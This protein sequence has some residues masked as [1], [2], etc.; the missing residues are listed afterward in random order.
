[1][2]FAMAVPAWML[3]VVSST[4]SAQ[5]YDVKVERNVDVKMRDGVILNTDIYRP[6]SMVN[7][8]SFSAGRLRTSRALLKPSTWILHIKPPR[9][10]MWRSF[11]T[12]AVAAPP[13]ASGIPSS[14]SHGMA[15]TP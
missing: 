9:G 4:F 5:H 14:M 1:M 13:K 15:T 3:L 11:R 12:C 6:K 10:A 2:G 7:S 8:P